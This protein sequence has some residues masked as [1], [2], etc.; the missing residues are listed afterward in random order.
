[1]R[2]RKLRIA[3]SVGCSLACLLLI[4]L[5]V[6][7][8]RAT[9][10][11]TL[12]PFCISTDGRLV[13][14]LKE[15]EVPFGGSGLRTIDLSSASLL[16]A[17]R[18]IDSEPFEAEPFNSRT[19]FHLEHDYRRTVLQLPYWFLTLLIAATAC[20]PWIPWSSRFGLR[21]LLIAITA[22]ALALGLSVRLSY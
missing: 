12:R 3:W 9:D 8:Y 1:M 4:V 21:T 11:F 7:S 5:W 10:V 6:R 2:F 13:I 14:W 15:N 16:Y 20:L 18:V 17:S 19:G 22:V